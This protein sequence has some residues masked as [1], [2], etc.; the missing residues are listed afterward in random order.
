[1]LKEAGHGLA[2]K[3]EEV[4]QYIKIIELLKKVLN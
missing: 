1:M 3:Q 2:S 4:L